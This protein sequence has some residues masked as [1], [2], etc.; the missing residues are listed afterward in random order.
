MAQAKY[1]PI[2]RL[3]AA[4]KKHMGI[5][6]R[7]A[8]EVGIAR[9][10]LAIRIASSPEL[11]EHIRHV[12]EDTLDLV[13]SVILGAIKNKDVGTARWYAERQGKSRGYATKL[14]TESRISDDQLEAIVESFGGDVEKLRAFRQSIDPSSAG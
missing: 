5:V 14:E 1:I 11:Q 6:A 12:K 13:D 4:L 8:K 7:A 3:K 2:G 9:Q 10:T